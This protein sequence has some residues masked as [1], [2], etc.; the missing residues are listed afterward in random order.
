MKNL[1]FPIRAADRNIRFIE[2]LKKD[3]LVWLKRIQ[4]RSCMHVSEFL[5][6]TTKEGE[7]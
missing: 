4:R 5:K 7:Y 2:R 6:V 3:D 1:R